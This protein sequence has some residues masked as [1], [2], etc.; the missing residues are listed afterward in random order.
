MSPNKLKMWDAHP[1]WEAA[2][3]TWDENA[4]KAAE[5]KSIRKLGH[6]PDMVGITAETKRF[7]KWKSFYWMATKD[8]EW[9]ILKG[10][11]RHPFRYAKNYV[12]S[13]F[14]S[15][16]YIRE[17]DFFLYGMKSLD[18]FVAKV[19]KP[20]TL[21]VVGFSYCHKPFECPSGRFTDEC[22]HDAENPVCQQ[23]FIGKAVHTLPEENVVPLFIPTVHYI[24]EKIFELIQA[25]P[26]KKI[27]FLITACEMTLEMFSDWG[28]MVGISG[29][30]VRLGG[31]ICNTMKAFELSEVG[32]K[33][34][35]TIVHEE[36][37]KKLLEL[38]RKKRCG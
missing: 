8:K 34:G 21:F 7:L 10:F 31:R 23:C 27:V 18:E 28:N 19:Q 22:I 17:G 29:V 5:I 20:E 24:G 33:P 25:Y 6:I 37:Q 12:K 26:K 15:K 4:K 38:L 9:A 14:S 13:L 1:T 2:E 32:I 3:S 35:L 36:T 16:R 30:G 11:L